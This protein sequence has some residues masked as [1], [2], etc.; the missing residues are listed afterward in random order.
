MPLRN[1]PI[2]NSRRTRAGLFLPLRALP[3]GERVGVRR[4]R[5]D[6]VAGFLRDRRRGVVQVF[7]GR[8]RLE[9]LLLQRLRRADHER[10]RLGTGGGADSSRHARYAH[11]QTTNRAYFCRIESGVGCDP[12]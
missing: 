2:R 6:R 8:D 10:A 3:Q 12:R 11:Q 9:A 1:C 5:N 7:Q 4:E